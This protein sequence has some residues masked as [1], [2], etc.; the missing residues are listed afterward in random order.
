MVVNRS[1]QGLNLC[2][3]KDGY[4]L[5]SQHLTTRSRLHTGFRAKLNR[6]DNLITVCLSVDS[7]HQPSSCKEV[8]LPIEL[9]RHLRAREVPSFNAQD[10]KS[11]EPLRVTFQI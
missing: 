8:A 9:D 2:I 6:K 10:Y 1:L 11:H 7:N 4:G 3:L 5:A